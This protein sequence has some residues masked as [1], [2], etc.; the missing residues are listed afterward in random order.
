[1]AERGS[2]AQP[3]LCAS[4]ETGETGGFQL[5]SKDMVPRAV[6]TRAPYLWQGA[7][8]GEG[9]QPASAHRGPLLHGHQLAHGEGQQEQWREKLPVCPQDKA[10]VLLLAPQPQWG[11]VL[12]SLSYCSPAALLLLPTHPSDPTRAGLRPASSACSRPWGDLAWI[13]PSQP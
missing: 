4:L 2:R 11:W 9:E 8:V 3:R 12:V 1:M 5:G 7:G 13:P 10:L 6:H